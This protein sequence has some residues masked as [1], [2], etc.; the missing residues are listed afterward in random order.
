STASRPEGSPRR[1]AAPP[2]RRWPPI[3]RVAAASVLAGSRGRRAL[4][5]GRPLRLE[6]LAPPI[7]RRTERNARDDGFEETQDDE[8]ARLVGRDAAALEVE[9]LRLVDRSDR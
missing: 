5:A 6:Q 7:A 9:E 3:C 8:L 1:I 4:R 2:P